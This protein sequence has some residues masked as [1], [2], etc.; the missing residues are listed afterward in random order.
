MGAG[1][2]ALLVESLTSGFTTLR[3]VGVACFVIAINAVLAAIR[4]A[5]LR[6]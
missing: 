3:A 2:I 4:E 1:L 5:R 6:R